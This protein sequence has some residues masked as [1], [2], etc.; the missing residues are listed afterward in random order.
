MANKYIIDGATYCGDGTTSAAAASAGA[1]GAWNTIAILEG[2]T[3]AYGVLAVGDVVNIRS[4]TAGGADLVRTLTSGLQIGS[5]APTVSTAPVTWILDNG[6][7]WA[8]IDG[9]LSYTPVGDNFGANLRAYNRLIAR[10]QNAIRF[11]TINAYGS[12]WTPLISNPG[13]YGKGLMIDA[14]AWTRG[15][16]V[17]VAMVSAILEDLYFDAGTGGQDGYALFMAAGYN[18]SQNTLINP[19][20]IKAGGVSS[21]VVTAGAYQGSGSFLVLGGSIS[22]ASTDVGMPLVNTGYGGTVTFIGTQIP[23]TMVLSNA[24]DL[25]TK[26]NVVGC[27]ADGTG[28]Y[29]QEGWGWA[30]SRTD[31]YPPVLNATLPDAG[32]TPWAYRVYMPEASASNVIRIPLTKLYVDTPQTKTITVEVLVA[33]GLT[34]TKDNLWAYIEYVDATTGITKH[35]STKDFS[36]AAS[37]TSTAAWSSATWGMI[38]FNKVK[39]TVTT[40]TTIKQDTLISVMVMGTL[41]SASANDVL[42]IDPD[43]TVS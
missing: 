43:F 30:T 23:R 13:S 15:Y 22:G 17:E 21:A 38:S 32:L 31:N 1:A 24:R 10:T 25:R 4:K 36:G 7:I 6:I 42:F 28:G 33:T 34:S 26:I 37:D 29:L 20:I 35:L 18:D 8:G 16:R 9:I 19:M 5:S 12:V 14:A 41:K 3:P 2:S 27:D 11:I 39:M 40:P